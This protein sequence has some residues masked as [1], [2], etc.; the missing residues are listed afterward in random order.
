MTISGVGGASV[1]QRHPSTEPYMDLI[2][3][4]SA[5]LNRLRSLLNDPAARLAGSDAKYLVGGQLLGLARKFE[6]LAREIETLPD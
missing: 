3:G 1:S 6:D 2:D 5:S 4:L